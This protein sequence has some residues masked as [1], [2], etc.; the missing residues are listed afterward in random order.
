M[1]LLY[2]LFGPPDVRQFRAKCDILRL[3]KALRYQKMWSVRRDAAVA[4]GGLKAATA[5]EPLCAA[6]KDQASAVVEVAAGALGEIENSRAVEPLCSVLDHADQRVR[7]N[8]TWALVRIGVAVVEPLCVALGQRS[9]L[10]RVYAAQALGE[11]GDARAVEPLC[12]VIEEASE[13]LCKHVEGVDDQIKEILQSE[14][15]E[16]VGALVKIGARGVEPLCAALK[17]GV[18]YVRRN[19]AEALGKIRDARAVEP[20]CAALEDRDG[21]VGEKVIAAL[22]AFGEPAVEPLRAALKD[23]AWYVRGNAAEALGK[24]GNP[25]A[26]QSLCDALGDQDENVREKVAE[27]LHALQ[28]RQSQ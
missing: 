22:V 16:A 25:R 13:R 27:A 18:W 15:T 4:L 28:I 23:E 5:V 8:A 11:I 17:D 3:I 9:W 21:N 2:G 7:E 24:I 6:L 14:R 20:L 10:L 26:E 1:S 19:A 12:A